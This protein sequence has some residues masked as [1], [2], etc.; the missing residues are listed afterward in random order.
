M[1]KIV[2]LSLNDKQVALTY[3]KG[4]TYLAQETN[5]P[6]IGTYPAHENDIYM[7]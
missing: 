3:F 5:F 2:I 1:L 6:C 4:G 7:V